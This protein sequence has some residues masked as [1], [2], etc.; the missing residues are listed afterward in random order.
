MRRPR[1]RLRPKAQPRPARSGLAPPPALALDRLR[2]AIYHV[3][4]VGHQGSG[5]SPSSLPPSLS[6]AHAHADI[7]NHSP[8][9]IRP[10]WRQKSA[11]L[12]VRCCGVASVQT[13]QY[14]LNRRGGF[15]A[16]RHELMAEHV[17]ARPTADRSHRQSQSDDPSGYEAAIKLWQMPASLS[18][19][20]DRVERMTEGL[21]YLSYSRFIVWWWRNRRSSRI[22]SPIIIVIISSAPP[23]CPS[24]KGLP[25]S[26]LGF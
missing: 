23:V 3:D 25:F 15:L 8:S 11:P 26:G 18:A 9:V 12:N 5:Y 21:I 4:I 24:R 14:V 17:D 16:I 13:R 19:G 22:R 1:A 6:L 2:P 10:S 7:V 20:C